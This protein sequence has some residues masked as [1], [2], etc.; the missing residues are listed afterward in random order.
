[1]V[2]ADKLVTI[3]LL[4]LSNDIK[5]VYPGTIVGH[6]NPIDSIMSTTENQNPYEN[7]PPFLKELFEKTVKN[8]NY[9]Q[10]NLVEKFLLNHANVFASSDKDLGRTDK[11][12]HQINTGAAAPIK[13]PMR[14]VPVHWQD[15]VDKHIDDMR[16]RNIIQESTSPWS[17]GIVLAKKKGGTMRFC[18]DYRRLNAVTVKD[19]YPLPRIDE[20]LDY[21]SGSLWFSTLDLCSGYWHVE[22]DSQDKP[23]TAFST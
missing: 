3:R 16:E 7:L 23:K 9:E 14:R 22:M 15:E 4:N 19:A 17:S 1:M 5:H 6:M 11:I 10:V 8:L 12:K 20:A 13:Q 18:V 21:L 2:N